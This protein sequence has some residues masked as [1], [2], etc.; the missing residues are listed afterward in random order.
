MS[1]SDSSLEA[2]AVKSW[3]QGKEESALS[4]IGSDALNGLRLLAAM[5]VIVFWG[6]AW[7]FHLRN[8]SSRT[9]RRGERTGKD[10]H[11]L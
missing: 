11:L 1:V 6:Q 7:P 2:L 3:A 8:R 4:Y 9:R 10:L 5:Y